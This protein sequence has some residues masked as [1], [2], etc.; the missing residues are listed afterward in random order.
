[1]IFE[2]IYMLSQSSLY[3]LHAGLVRCVR[4]NEYALL[5]DIEWVLYTLVY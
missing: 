4:I 3:A 1:M 5:I 2:I